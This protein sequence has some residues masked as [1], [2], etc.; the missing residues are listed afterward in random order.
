MAEQELYYATVAIK[1]KI[2]LQPRVTNENETEYDEVKVNKEPPQ[3]KTV[4]EAEVEKQNESVQQTPDQT[5]KEAER[6]CRYQQLCC[7]FG[8]L[9]VILVLTI[10][11]VWVY[12]RVSTAS[13]LNQL[14]SSQKVLLE[15][16]QNLTNLNN[17]LSSD[18]KNLTIQFDNLTTASI[19]LKNNITT[20]IVENYNL[21]V[22]TTMLKNNITTLTVENYNLTVATT[23]LK[24]N[25]TTLTVENYNLTVATT[26]L[27]NNITTLTAEN[28]NLTV[29]TTM[30]KNN[31]TTL[32]VENYNLTVATTMLKNNI[33]TLTVE[34][35]NLTVATTMLKNN[36]TTLTV[37]NYN[38]TVATTMLKNNITTLTTE[39]RNLTTINE[40]LR[41]DKKNLT[42][43]I[44]NMEETWNE[45]NVSR[46]QWSI[47]V[48][49]PKKNGGR[50]CTSCQNGWNYNL[51][52]CY[53]YNDAVPSNQRNWEGAREDCRSKISDL[54]VVS[55]NAEKDYVKTQS[56][57]TGSIT[58]FWIGLRAVE[59]KW[60]WLDGSD[61]T[62][63]TWIQQPATDGKC[64]TSLQN[65]EWT[66]VNCT[67]RNAWICEKKAL[68]V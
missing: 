55:N 48:Y 32:T 61:L 3:A 15:E 66:S 49:C 14:K 62:N 68:S 10:I 38:L 35:Y 17:K 29:A 57:A 13:E 53:A 4:K 63:Q 67:E 54:T 18:Y 33:T 37:E 24:N 23:M 27:K 50:N 22:A 56:P 34:N 40:E 19:T 43:L 12:F 39:N 51:S 6:F 21:T 30:L 31:I 58:G 1:S 64:V 5:V 47:D 52:S 46:A 65:R 42:E 11:G 20:L 16:N 7:C 45:L 9:C 59:G 41:K 44:K 2:E 60:K 8:T 28:Y 36:I 26:M 25:I